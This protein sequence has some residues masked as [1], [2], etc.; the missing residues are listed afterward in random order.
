METPTRKKHCTRLELIDSTNDDWLFGKDTA[1][2]EFSSTIV[3]PLIVD[4]QLN[5]PV[6]VETNAA[7]APPTVSLLEQQLFIQNVFDRVSAD[8]PELA[9]TISVDGNSRAPALT[10]TQRNLFNHPPFG[11]TSRIQATVQY[12]SYVASVLMRSWKVGE[13]KSVED[14]IE[15]C[16]DFSNKSQYKFCPG[17]NPHDYEEEYHKV[18]RFHIKTVRLCHFPFM[19]VDSINCKLWFIPALNIPVVEKTSSE[20]KCP[21]CKRLIH[22]LNYQKKKTVAESPSRKIQRQ[23]PSSR[24]RLQYMSPLSQQ[25]RKQYAQYER[26]NSIRKLARYEDSEL[27]LND[28]QNE[29][30]CAIVEAVQTEQMEKL[31]EEGDQHGVGNLMKNIWFT[32]KDR[33]KSEFSSDQVHNSK[34]YF[35]YS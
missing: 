33:Q 31:F 34:F 1:T 13:V 21:A 11:L 10:I 6:I 4:N 24:A 23:L 28:E 14:V 30:M 19:R 32:D 3:D 25:K 9:F 8:F 17:I 7:E 5:S 26:T 22:D 2:D 16:H 20:V 27:V 15:L 18:I 35:L 29:E 12:K